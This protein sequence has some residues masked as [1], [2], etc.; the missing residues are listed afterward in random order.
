MRRFLTFRYITIFCLILLGL[1]FYILNFIP[2]KAESQYAF[3]P[4][5]LSFDSSTDTD[6]EMPGT[7]AIATSENKG[8]Q[9]PSA[10]LLTIKARGTTL[11]TGESSE[12]IIGKLGAPG[13]IAET[14]YD[15]DFYI[16][17]NNYRQL[18][19]IAIAEGQAVGFYTDSEDFD[20]MGIKSGSSLDTVNKALKQDYGISDIIE[21]KAD[22]Y[23][24]RLFM[25][26]LDSHKVS[27]IYIM[28]DKV[29]PDEYDETA[30]RS[31]ELIVYDLTNSIRARHKRD[32]LSWS[33]S[34]AKAAR[35]HSRDMADNRFFSHTNLKKENPADRLR[36]EGIFVSIDSEN[37]IAG[38]G[39]VF[40]SVHKLYNSRT[41]RNNLLSNHIRY[42]G[43]GFAYK[44]DSKY[45]TYITQNL[46][47]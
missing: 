2:H 21:Y 12:A 5:G 9:M 30:M 43:V 32:L 16:Y 33:S 37:L 47:R 27:G 19:F 45:T 29:K 10:N 22:D 14:E 4:S 36:A 39:S 23:T 8:E 6:T 26:S 13:R 18:L 31:L 1:A 3:I 38:Y 35:K 34:A 44:P 7:D 40:E 41:H 24:V 11:S 17:N 25:D 46:Y 28:S 20:Y 42:I 15:Y